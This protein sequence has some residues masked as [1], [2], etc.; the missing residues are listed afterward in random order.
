MVWEPQSEFSTPQGNEKFKFNDKI[1]KIVEARDLCFK[2]NA[3]LPVPY[4]EDDWQTLLK[5]I[6]IIHKGKLV[7][8]FHL[9]ITKSY[10]KYS[11]RWTGTGITCKQMIS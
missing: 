9:G 7:K 4:D 2:L 10:E 5:F 6:T 8:S 1:N 11:S 3:M